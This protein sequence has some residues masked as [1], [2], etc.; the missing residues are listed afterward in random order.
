MLFLLLDNLCIIGIY[1]ISVIFRINIQF[2]LAKY[3]KF[4]QKIYRTVIP[5]KGRQPLKSVA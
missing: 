3:F 5:C 2:N 4:F 1:V